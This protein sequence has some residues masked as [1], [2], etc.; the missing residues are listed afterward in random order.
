Y[1]LLQKLP[2]LRDFLVT[3]DIYNLNKDRVLDL[4]IVS[5]IKDYSHEEISNVIVYPILQRQKEV[6]CIAL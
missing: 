4:E 1:E 5:E 2:N 3:F 6:N